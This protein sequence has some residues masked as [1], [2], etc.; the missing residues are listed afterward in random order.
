MA[1]RKTTQQQGNA[2]PQANDAISIHVPEL[3][4]AYS[5]EYGRK[6]GSAQAAVTSLNEQIAS[7]LLQFF[8]KFGQAGESLTDEVKA[9]LYDGYT[10]RFAAKNPGQLYLVTVPAGSTF[11]DLTPLTTEQYQERS[12]AYEADKAAGKDPAMLNVIDMTAHVAMAFTQHQINF[13]HLRPAGGAG[14]CGPVYK[15]AVTDMRDRVK[16]FQANCFD[17]LEKAAR[18]IQQRR[19]A[20]A[21]VKR[22]R[23]QAHEF[24]TTIATL[25]AGPNGAGQHPKDSLAYKVR[26]RKRAGDPTADVEKFDKAIAAFNEIWLG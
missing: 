19:Q 22:T 15:A 10:D 5:S 11:C 24:G 1:T 17:S 8:P 3:P 20:E 26:A 4:N 13:L 9:D 2:A 14:L 21:G 25:F 12:A 16:R 23:I 7:N 18:N 6:L